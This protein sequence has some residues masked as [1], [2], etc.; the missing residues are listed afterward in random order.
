M[1]KKIVTSLLTFALL[2][3]MSVYAFTDTNFHW[4]KQ[5]IEFA[6]DSGFVSGYTDGT[7]GPEESLTRAQFAAMITQFKQG[8]QA[9]S[10]FQDVS[11]KD[12]FYG[13]V[14]YVANK[15]IMKGYPD[16]SFQPYNFITRAEVAATIASM[17]YPNE[18]ESGNQFSDSLPSWATNAINVTAKHG[19]FS[20]DTKNQFRPNDYLTR[21]EAATILA[22]MRGFVPKEEPKRDPFPLHDRLREA[23]RL[24]YEYAEPQGLEMGT[25]AGI[26]AYLYTKIG[27]M[28]DILNDMAIYMGGSLNR[29][30]LNEYRTS[31]ADKRFAEEGEGGSMA[32]ILYGSYEEEFTISVMDSLAK[33]YFGIYD[34]IEYYYRLDSSESY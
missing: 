3:P 27:Y 17:E 7:Y 9:A 19:I 24:A 28:D 33:E 10:N 2:A 8:T 30:E 34:T 25:T 13:F 6:R 29:D 1:K 32:A 20:G 15:G 23:V 5:Y 21:A 14:G 18:T 16:G 4:A 22:K 31:Y 26:V 11:K 12:W